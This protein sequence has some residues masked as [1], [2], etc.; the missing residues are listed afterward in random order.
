MEMAQIEHP[1]IFWETSPV[2]VG[3]EREGLLA[4]WVNISVDS[5]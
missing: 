3:E 4:A 5:P 1:Q 2:A